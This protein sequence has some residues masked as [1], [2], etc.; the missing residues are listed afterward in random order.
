MKKVKGLLCFIFALGFQINSYSQKKVE[1]LIFG[2]PERTYLTNKWD[3]EVAVIAKKIPSYSVALGVMLGQELGNNVR[4]N[5]GFLYSYQAQ[6]NSFFY[7]KNPNYIGRTILSYL[8]IPVLIQ[9]NYWK[10]G[11]K[12]FFIQAGPQVSLL[13]IEK[14]IIFNN[15]SVT[16][17]GG[18]YKSLVLDGVVALGM[19]IKIKK[20]FF[21]SLQIRAD[22]SLHNVGNLSYESLN[23]NGTAPIYDLQGRPRSREYNRTIGVLNGVCF[24]I[25]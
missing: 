18:G 6:K 4:I 5:Y 10:E 2:M 12:T 7:V 15:L 14:G 17:A 20:N 3:N 21:Y 16:E 19:E 23:E 11:N 8:K 9:Y 1:V 25:E 24:K 22:H 13:V